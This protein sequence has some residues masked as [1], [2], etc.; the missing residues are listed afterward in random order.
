M[1]PSRC[2]K[3]RPYWDIHS[4]QKISSRFFYATS[5]SCAWIQ[6]LSPRSSPRLLRL[7]TIHAVMVLY[8]PKDQQGCQRQY[9]T[10]ETLATMARKCPMMRRTR[11]RSKD[12]S[13]C[14]RL[15]VGTLASSMLTFSFRLPFSSVPDTWSRMMH[16]TQ[17]TSSR[18]SCDNGWQWAQPQ[19]PYIMY[20]SS[21]EPH[22]SCSELDIPTSM[23]HSTL[24]QCTPPTWYTLYMLY[25]TY[26]PPRMLK[27]TLYLTQTNALCLTRWWTRDWTA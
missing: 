14:T 22:P 20:N 10:S 25:T 6:L 27:W 16:G 9:T 7:T 23:V 8:K 1:M 18:T 12:N 17:G 26:M 5:T 3:L 13:S 21:V 15:L 2:G 11:R 24:L 19:R 4:Y